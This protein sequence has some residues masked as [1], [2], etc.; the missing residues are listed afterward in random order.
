M[1][2]ACQ[3]VVV[4]SGQAQEHPARPGTASLTLNPKSFGEETAVSTPVPT[5]PVA[6]LWPRARGRTRSVVV[7]GGGVLRCRLVQASRT[8]VQEVWPGQ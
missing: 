7:Q 4:V 5:R 6:G 8:I 2:S 1:G 3:D